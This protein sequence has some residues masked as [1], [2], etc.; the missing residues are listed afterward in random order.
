MTGL[1]L[2]PSPAEYLDT[3]RGSVAAP[4][5]RGGLLELLA[6]L[7]ELHDCEADVADALRLVVD[8]ARELLGSDVSWGGTVRDGWL[9][10]SH[11]SGTRTDAIISL[12]SSPLALSISGAAL[13]RQHTLIV[14]D[15]PHY[16]GPS[17]PEIR[18]AFLG[19]GIVS[20]MVAPMFRGDRLVGF[21][22]V[23][24]RRATEFSEVHSSLLSTLAAQASVAML[25]A[26][27]RAEL[28]ARNELLAESLSI[29][30]SLTSS[31]LRRGGPEAVIGELEAI[32]DRSVTLTTGAEGPPPRNGSVEPVPVVA[33]DD[34]LGWLS[35]DGEALSALQVHAVHHA[36]S[37]MAL[38]LLDQ[39][40]I[41]DAE[42]RLRAEVL[43]HLVQ[44]DGT[45]HPGVT[46]RA[47]RLGHD[48]TLAV[49]LIAI[50]G[51]QDSER[52]RV[53]QA[54]RDILLEDVEQDGPARLATHHGLRTVIAV[55]PAQAAALAGDL[56]AR[57]AARDLKVA[58]GISCPTTELGAAR[59]EALACLA[60]A[61]RSTSKRIVDADRMGPLRFMLDI[62]DWG[63][64]IEHVRARLRPLAANPRSGPT[65][66]ST[67]QAYV[68]ADG[69]QQ[70]VAELCGIHLNTLKYRL[71]RIEAALGYRLRDADRRFDLRLTFE[72]LELLEDMGRDPLS[73][74]TAD[75][76]LR[77]R[78]GS[79]AGRRT[80][81]G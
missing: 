37:A 42:W 3:A 15:Y 61:M 4:P 75:E 40:A 9:T 1:A 64:A 81:A 48:A 32:L 33:G 80:P 50:E 52:R 77:A 66:L 73:R 69:H 31:A 28:R 26:S 24:N 6:A 45:E 35:V 58:I 27:L 10:M 60:L 78:T 8:K 16:H 72:L 14:N 18:R 29:H 59:D 79:G 76:P 68:E 22:N 19:E 56:E 36:A 55:A 38:E 47:I 2:V 46:Q 67:A 20:L 41:R 25:N 70:T 34:T 39:R 57:L 7:R 51:V 5:P 53:R 13:R 43:E 49:C 65:L 21:V 11:V 62:A 63:D 23:G 30:R 71:T 12:P 44:G 74:R 54:V 17:T